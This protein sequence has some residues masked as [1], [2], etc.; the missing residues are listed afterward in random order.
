MEWLS[1]KHG[2]RRGVYDPAWG[3]DL[4]AQDSRKGTGDAG[5]AVLVLH[6]YCHAHSPKL[7]LL[8]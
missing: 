5:D 1:P 4:C 7:L 2:D 8:L 6:S 3:W